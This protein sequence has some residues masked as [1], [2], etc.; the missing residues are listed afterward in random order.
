L[1]QTFVIPHGVAEAQSFRPFS[2]TQSKFAFVGRLVSTKGVDL[3]L[4]ASRELQQKGFDFKVFIIGDGPERNRLEALSTALGLK[5]IE[6]AGHVPDHEVDRLTGDSLAVV[7]PSIA[8]EVFGLVAAENMM[9]GHAVIVSDEGAL[10]EIVGA[11]GL[12]FVAGDATSLARSMEY[13]LRSPAAASESGACARDRAL[14]QFRAEQMSDCHAILY[15]E[16]LR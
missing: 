7:E 14:R 1:P 9:R 4:R 11:S 13:L 5:N 2:G 8:G 6:F 3:L 16:V 12:Q 10:A 15:Q